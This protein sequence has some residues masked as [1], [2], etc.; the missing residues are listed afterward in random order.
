MKREVAFGLARLRRGP[1]LRFIVWS[2]P[3]AAPTAVLGFAVAHAIDDG[4]LRGRPE[5]GLIWLALV[6]LAGAF[7]AVG[8]RQVLRALGE[9]VE[10]MRDELVGRV[11][12]GALGR[13]V[14]GKPDDGAV[15][16]LTRQVEQVRDSYA[17]LLL[18]IRGSAMTVVAATVGLLSLSREITLVILPLFL[19]GLSAFCVSLGLAARWQR[20]A[21]IAD[22][23][24]ASA[25]TTVLAGT[26]DVIA[27]GAESRA[28][29]MVYEPIE[30]QAAAERALARMAML[31]TGCFAVGGWLPLLALLA[32][33]PWLVGR[34]VSA[35]AILGGLTYVLFGLQPA[36][37][38]LMGGLGGGGVRFVITL[39]RL[40][41]VP[42]TTRDRL[43]GHGGELITREVTFA[44][45]PHSEPVLKRLNL[46]IPQGDHLAVIG[47]SGIGKS[48]LAAI[49][50]GLL[51]P[52]SGSVRLSSPPVLIP[53]EA[54]VF[55]GSVRENLCYLCDSEPSSAVE[56]VGASALVE[57]LGGYDAMVEPSR[58]SAGERQL[59]ALARAY[60]SP[61]PIVVLDE[62]TCHLDPAAEAVAEQAFA[63]RRG[64]LV[65]IAH[66]VS[67]AL[68][69]R[70][71]LVLDGDS[72]V[73]GAHDDLLARS[74]F[75]RD[76][77]SSLSPAPAGS[78]RSLS[79]SRFWSGCGTDG[80]GPS[81]C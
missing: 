49:L 81:R 7:S 26:R 4:F 59:I 76:V 16:R 65:V 31:R 23:R 53:Q 62:A 48:T 24:L 56:A 9:L 17:G 44:Y 73:V 45:G 63:R 75:Y 55:T 25:A 66:R 27:S 61:S 35:G 19:L 70:R 43:T 29:A 10:P 60:H 18:T 15:G 40:L 30:A 12:H 64:T 47:P 2:V 36:L 42:Q 14:S 78:P 77:I 71:I 80:C 68:R 1:L 52:T 39:G 74:P 5:T 41:D 67:S 72:A 33:G 11:V 32:A 34:G 50:C 46:V 37:S 20:S 54:Y 3:E 22:E 28:A 57:R 21:A 79:G 8:S 6:L 38:R 13:A 51:R 69:A 58:L